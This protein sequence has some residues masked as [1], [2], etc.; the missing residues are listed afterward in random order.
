MD[1][2]KKYK[3]SMAKMSEFLSKHNGF[4]IPKYYEVHKELS[5][6]FPELKESDDEKIKKSL[7]ILLQ[8]FCKGYR[9][10]GLDFPVSYKEMLDLVEKQ[11]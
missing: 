3:E 11:D 4:T 2:E 9:V 7:I 8:H 5:E 6:I 10:P 1:Y